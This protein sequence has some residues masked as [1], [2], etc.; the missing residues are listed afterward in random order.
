MLRLSSYLILS[1]R[2]ENGGYA[3]LSGLSGA[4]ELISEGLYELL[5]EIIQNSPP[6]L[7]R[8]EEDSLPPDIL[9][10]FI[11]RGHITEASHEEERAY[12]KNVAS[13]LHELA[14]RQPGVVIIPNLD[15]NY[16]CTYCFEKPL[17]SNLKKRKTK[18]G[19]GDV[20]AVYRAIAQLESESGFTTE[21]ITLYGGEPLCAEN[22]EIVMHIIDR[23]IEKGYKF[24]AVTNGH[25]LDAYMNL[26]GENNI[27]ALQITIDG[28]KDIH[29][30]RRIALD[31]SS[32][33][34]KIID[35]MRRAIGE[36]DVSVSV[37][38]NL[39]G[40]N[41][42][43]FGELLN[44]FEHEGW[45]N[46][47]R[48]LV[49]AAIV[50]Q[51]DKNG[52]I[53]PLQDINAVKTELSGITGRYANVEMGSHQSAYGDSVLSSL[54]SNKP[55]GLRSCFCA[56]NSGM[57]I[58]LPDKT[59]SSCWDSIGEECSYIGSY[60]EEGLFLDKNK[61]AR[62]FNRS[63]ANIPA[64]L[65]CKY[66]LVCAGG[67]AQYAEYNFHDIYQPYCG[68]FKT[69]YSWVLAEAVEKYLRANGF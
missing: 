41:Y 26:L 67:C 7:L 17:H 38:V 33:F 55:Y 43:A 18:M 12:V 27:S 10:T 28:P 2:L 32:S 9:E 57:Y 35:N 1:D 3:A 14:A 50:S 52:V 54:V 51:K 59:I 44:I 36:T 64:C 29:D 49:T 8:I 11:K 48:I 45:L 58:F 22:M 63:V 69:T 47:N 60:S 6:Q 65:D 42:K 39:D 46:N 15:C 40:E 37:R 31:G 13:A 16:R 20:D 53:S 56:S 30:R 4:I 34:Q 61:T 5:H 19:I 24:A 62:K 66:C 25:D 21:K 68:D 23:G